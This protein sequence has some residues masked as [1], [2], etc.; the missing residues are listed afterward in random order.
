MAKIDEHIKVMMLKGETGANIKSIDKTATSGLVDTY[1]VTLTDGTKSSFTVTNGKDGADFDTFEIGGR[2]LLLGTTSGMGW[3]G[4]VGGDGG[5]FAFDAAEQA[6]S[7]SS[8]HTTTV[9]EN[10]IETSLDL[11]PDTQYTLSAWIKSNGKVASVDFHCADKSVTC[12]RSLK[13]E[14]VPT[15]YK[16]FELAFTTDSKPDWSGAVI[17]FDNNG[18]VE[19]GTEAILY[20]KHPQLERGNKPSDW[21]P[22]PED[23]AN[24]STIVRTE[25]VESTAMASH[26]YADGDYMVVNGLLRRATA[27]IAKGDAISDGNSTDTTV[28][29]EIMKL[30]RKV[31]ETDTWHSLYDTHSWSV[32]YTERYG[33]LYIRAHVGKL[34]TSWWKAGTLPLG[35]RPQMD[36]YAPVYNYSEN[37]CAGIFVGKNGDVSMHS[38]QA[39]TA[40]SSWAI[41]SIPLW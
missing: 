20:V 29:A 14:S 1:T 5:E 23:K 22:A 41:V 28:S 40:T 10:Y 25:L 9:N 6:F 36:F 8:K 7:I 3:E 32:Y 2:N 11:E 31:G 26:A 30:A 33:V 12:I 15:E 27:A 21:T 34:D 13:I 35:Y 4:K 16:R 19:D 38:Y 18:S 17:R 24:V 37:A 39:Q